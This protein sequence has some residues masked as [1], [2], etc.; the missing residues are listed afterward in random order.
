MEYLIDGHNIILSER[1]YFSAS[2]ESGRR[3]ELLVILRD[4]LTTRRGVR[5]TVVFDG[6]EK[7]S[8]DRTSRSVP[9]LR[10]IFAARDLTADQMIDQIVQKAPNPRELTVVSSD[11]QVLKNAEY[12]GANTMTSRQFLELVLPDYPEETAER[13]PEILTQ[14]ELDDWRKYF[15]ID[16]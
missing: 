2:T 11:R 15:G 7:F 6:R 9:R 12:S 8:T 3:A 10:V 4:Y 14:E 13:K 5:I 1:E 16:D